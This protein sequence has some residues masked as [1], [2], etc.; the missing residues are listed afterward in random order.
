MNDKNSSKIEILKQWGIIL[1]IV[2]SIISSVLAHFKDETVAKA[3]YKELSGAVKTISENQVK[4]REDVARIQG[5]IE[6]QRNVQRE[7]VAEMRQEETE[8]KKANLGLLGSRK[9]IALKSTEEP[10]LNKESKLDEI[11]EKTNKPLPKLKATAQAYIP[12]TLEELGK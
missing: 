5:A 2:L 4:I 7:I 1:G 11:A 8:K 3:A 9:I 10:A 12:P 6:G